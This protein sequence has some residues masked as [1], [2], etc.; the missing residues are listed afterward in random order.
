MEIRKC[1]KNEIGQVKRLINKVFRIE[2]GFKPTMDKEFPLLLGVNN[3][4]NI[5]I[6]KKDDEIVSCAAYYHNKLILGG[7]LIKLLM[8]A[9]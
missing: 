7:T 3:C 5:V 4:D 2:L 1:Y 6:S 8:N 9:I